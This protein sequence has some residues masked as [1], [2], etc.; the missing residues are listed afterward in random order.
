MTEKMGQDKNA[1]MNVIISALQERAKE[2][3]CLYKVEELLNNPDPNQDHIFNEIVRA[4]PPGWQYP[5]KCF[6]KLN[7]EDKTYYSPNLKETKWKQQADITVQ[8]N[9]IGSIN[10]YYSEE[11]PNFDEGPFLK[12]ERKL[13]NTIAERI[14]NF[15]LHNKLKN[16]FS[17]WQNNQT[18]PETENKKGE[19]KIAVG[20]LKETDNDL[21]QLIARKMMNFLCW[22]G[23]KEAEQLL[24]KSGIAKKRLGKELIEDENKPVEKRE[25]Q[26]VREEIFK[27]AEENLSDE[28][29]S[30]RIQKWIQED[31]SSFLVR[32]LENLGTTLPEIGDAIRRYLNIAPEYSELAPAIEKGIDVSLIRRFLSDQLQF[33]SIAKNF[34]EIKDFYELLQRMIFPAKSHGKLGGKSVGLFIASKILK[35]STDYIELF[36]DIKVP[37]TWYITSDAIID[38]LHYNNLEEVF[39][40]KYKD[41][42]QIRQEYPYI[43]QVF[44]N[45][46]FPTEIMKDLSVALDDLGN[47]PLI[48]RSSSLLED[49]IGAAFSGKYKSLFVANQ[50]TKQQRLSALTDAIAE[51]Y[52]SVFNT[53]PIEYRSERGLLDYN[54]EMG[55]MVQEVVGTRVGKYFFPTYA[56]VAFSNNEFRWSPRIKREDGLVRIV[57]GLGTRAVDRVSDDYP[58]MIAPGKPGLRVN[59]TVDEVIRYSPRKIDVINLENNSFETKDIDEILN[60][61]GE[62]YPFVTDIVSNVEHDQI[63][64]IIELDID[65]NRK[66]LVV[67]FDR[68]FTNSNFVSKLQTILKVLKEKL[69]TPVDIEFASDGN[70]FYLLQ[71]RPQSYSKESM[72]VP[73]PRDIPQ[74]KIIFSANKYISNGKVPDITHI[75]YVNPDAY[76]EVSELNEL[77]EVGRAV[78]KLNKML[79]KRQF[80]LMGPGRWGSRGDI[81]LGVNVTYSDIN[82][83]AVL[84]EIAKK[85]GN[86]LPDLSFGT[87]FFQDLVESQI[88]YLPLYPDDEGIIFN[89]KFL[90]NSYN[91]LP[92]ILPE[93]ARLHKVVK[94][95]DVPSTTEGMTLKV[96]MNADLDEAIGILSVPTAKTTWNGEET[97]QTDTRSEDAW[98]WRYRMAEKI[99]AMLD[100]EKFGVKAFYIFGSVKNATAGPAS[101]IDILIHSI[102]NQHQSAELKLW[103]EGWSLCLSEM[104]YLRTGYK[105]E[106]ILD[107][108]IIT[109]EDIKNKDSFALKIGAI[110][111]AAKE[112][113]LKK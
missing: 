41:L 61:Y 70:N 34:V 25:M 80:I 103:L 54:E 52:A 9:I 23:V 49:R 79:P 108:H 112:I 18:I 65:S 29:I 76:N 82:N 35:K 7:I 88:R 77:V 27:I 2:L 33:I 91:I 50:G 87:H 85:K 95:I 38:F 101:D 53:D 3:N 19:W 73:I 32:I 5:D 12:E 66:N 72:P 40:Q 111:D 113:P 64:K 30:F 92:D 90:K 69:G 97:K 56:G 16:V 21:Y 89:E 4:L 26:E 57:P 106:N 71:C 11:K 81:K 59:V 44:K 46:Q 51:V 63:K 42:D 105:T 98:R 17:E 83:T 86:Y 110:T 84:I 45:S 1:S 10:I 68:L 28:E 104:N 109:N 48:V 78:G 99:A 47:V 74:E 58:V 6:V 39:E 22:S 93:F 43:V 60:F 8:G 107:A 102:G 62:K 14:G 15:L 13:I 20:L 24:Q 55:I 94:V 37:K 75:V 100:A 36:K 31:K 67:T 96:L